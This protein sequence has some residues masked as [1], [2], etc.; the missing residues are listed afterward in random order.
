MPPCSRLSHSM[1][2]NLSLLAIES[3]LMDD[4]SNNDVIDYFATSKPKVQFILP[5]GTQHGARSTEHGARNTPHAAR[6]IS[7]P[8]SSHR[9][10]NR[11]IKYIL[12]TRGKLDF[13]QLPFSSVL[14]A[15]CCLLLAACCFVRAAC[16]VVRAA[17]C[18]EV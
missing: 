10:C 7:I 4:I 8:T 15:A 5:R 16:S 1:L 6:I 13:Q 12:F 11:M 3:D 2:G 17:C 18:V 9:P 14:R